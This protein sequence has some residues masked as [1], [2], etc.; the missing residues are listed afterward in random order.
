MTA[1]PAAPL[2]RLGVF[3]GAFDPPHRAHRA[4]AEAALRQLALDALLIVPTGQAWHKARAL[5]DGAH[6]LAMCHLAFDDLPGVRVDRREIDRRGPTYTVDTLTE[7]HAEHPD[8]ALFLIVGADQWLAIRTWHRWADILR[9]CTVA[10]ANRP[11]AGPQAPLPDLA[12][13]GLPHVV[14]DVPPLD[15]SATALRALWHD[16]VPPCADA[17]ALVSPAVARYISDHRLY[18]SPTPDA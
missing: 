11:L 13:V 15:V 2:G 17:Q 10:V 18:A 5:S 16:G 7:L 12:T 14:L 3:G 8:A 9:L 6:R 4:V 1:R